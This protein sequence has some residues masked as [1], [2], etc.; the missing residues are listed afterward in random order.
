M[1]HAGIECFLAVCRYKTGSRAAES[2]FITQSSLSTRLKAL[3]KE[4]GGP[5]FYRKQ[6]GFSALLTH[7]SSSLPVS[8]KV[9]REKRY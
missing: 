6:G 5:L 9:R 8:K 3:E 2:L 1:T 7:S 4:L